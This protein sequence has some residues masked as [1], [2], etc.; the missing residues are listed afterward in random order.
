MAKYLKKFKT[1]EEFL[2]FKNSEDFSNN[3]VSYVVEYNTV[4]FGIKKLLPSEIEV[5]TNTIINNIIN[6]SV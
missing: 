3:T 5:V 4:W 1:E 2:E 6:T